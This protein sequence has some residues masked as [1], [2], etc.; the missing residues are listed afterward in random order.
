[1]TQKKVKNT[2]KE[3]LSPRFCQS[4]ESFNMLLKNTVSVEFIGKNYLPYLLND[5]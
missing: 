3:D 4:S 1:M 2:L 5:T